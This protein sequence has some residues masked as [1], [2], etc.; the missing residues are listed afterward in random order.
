MALDHLPFTT[1]KFQKSNH[2][3]QIV[4]IFYTKPTHALFIYPQIPS[5]KCNL[6]SSSSNGFITLLD[7]RIKHTP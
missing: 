2:L 3:K 1:N 4:H 6:R 5:P 7:A